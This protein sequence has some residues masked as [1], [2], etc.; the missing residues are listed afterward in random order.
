VTTALVTGASA[1]I[2]RAFSA[3]LASRGYDVVLVARDEARLT[4]LAA[5]L[6]STHRV[7]AH[8]LTADLLTDDGLHTVEARL[9]DASDPIELLVNNAGMGTFGDFS[10]TDIDAEE[11]EIRLNVLA[12]VR[13]AHA[14]LEAMVPRRSGAVLNVSSLAAYQPAPSSATYAATKAFVNSFTQSVHEECRP[15]GVHVMA[16]CPGYTHTELHERAGLGPTQIPEFMWMEADD[17]VEVA[18]RDLDRRR[19][20]SIPGTF[21][22]VLGAAS[23]IAPTAVTRR[24]AGIVIRRSG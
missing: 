20:V 10:T 24:V 11:R 17:V 23:S 4:E 22:K 9:R 18:L 13:L 14:A 7:E 5:T 8:V 12:L 19:V 15:H 1:G 21:Y 2:G 3:G 6:R 16:L